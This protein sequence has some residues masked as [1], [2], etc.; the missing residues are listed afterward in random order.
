MRRNIPLQ[1]LEPIQERERDEISE[2]GARDDSDEDPGVVRHDAEHQ[3]VAQGHLQE[4]EERLDDVK[5]PAGKEFHSANQGFHFTAQR[6]R[7]T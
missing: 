7:F 2:G 5:R 1:I 3:H 4:V 6:K